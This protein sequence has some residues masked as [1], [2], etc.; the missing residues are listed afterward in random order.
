MSLANIRIFFNPEYLFN[1][2]PNYDMKF[3]PQLLG[4]FVILLALSIVS[5]IF[6]LRNRKRPIKIVLA[7]IYNWLLWSGSVGLVLL[8]FRYEGVAFAS[9]RFLLF[10]WIL[11]FIGW[12]MYLIWFYKK[13]YKKIL[14]EHKKE[15]EKEKYIKKK[16]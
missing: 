15:K 11:M 14:K 16:K 10:M 7:Y 8:F 1:P 12:G 2:Y 9:M 3:M 6:L 4:F 13:K 5:F